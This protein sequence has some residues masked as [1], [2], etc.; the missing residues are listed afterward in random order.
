MTVAYLS[1]APVEL[2]ALEGRDVDVVEGEV[3]KEFVLSEQ[4]GCFTH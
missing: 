1:V 2:V 4:E 3:D